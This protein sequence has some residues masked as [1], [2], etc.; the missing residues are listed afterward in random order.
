MKTQQNYPTNSPDPPLEPA[1]EV[2][3][4][5]R[6]VPG[7]PKPGDPPGQPRPG[8]P[9]P[10]KPSPNSPG[11]IRPQTLLTL[12]MAALLGGIAL[13]QESPQN[14]IDDNDILE[15]IEAELRFDE[16]VSAD[17]IDVRVDEGIV[18]LS[19]NAFTLLA[20]QRAVRLVGSLKGVRTVVDR[21]A[22]TSTRRTDQEILDDVKA[23]LRDDPVVEAQQIRVT[24]ANGKVTLEG[25]VDSFAE[26]QL[27]ARAVTGVHGVVDVD[28]Q[29]TS[30]ADTKRPDSEIRPEI[31]RRFELSPY[32]AEGLIEVDVQD[33]IVSL[34]GVV[35]S[36]NERGIASVLARVAGVRKVNT[37]DL[38]VKWWLDRERRR[39]KFTVV[40][41]D[42]QIKKAVEDALLYDPRVRGAKV[43]VRT[44]Q[45]AVSL[46]G[47][48]SSLAAKRAAEQDAKNTL[49]VRRV[50]NNL[51][52][53]VPDWPGDLEV[54]K[55]ATEAL[56]RDAH[57]FASNLKASSHFGKVFVSGTVNSYFE[58]QRAETVVANVRGAMEVVNRVSVDAR[59]QPKEDGEIYEDVER[60]FRFSSIVDAE[61]IRISVVDGVVALRGT[62]DT[63]HEKTLAT[64]HANQGG[65]L[66]VINKLAV[67]S[68]RE[69]PRG[70][71]ATIIPKRTTYKLDSN[72]NTD[73][74]RD[75]LELIEPVR[76]PS[77]LPSPPEVDLVLKLQNTA[78]LPVGVRLGHDKGSLDLSLVGDGAINVS[79]EQPVVA[80]FRP[81]RVVTIKPGDHIKIPIESLQ[82]GFRNAS[83]RWYWTRPGDYMLQATLIWPTDVTGFNMQHVEAAPVKLI[84]ST[85][86]KDKP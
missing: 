70:L 71:K 63:L 82:Y 60:R 53:K 54:T 83:D 80:D 32:L 11:P 77:A 57:L 1:P 58:K 72:W 51:K 27:T 38:E 15:A 62:V 73:E 16:A 28:N 14:P 18:E 85:K 31:L 3:P 86:E 56:G 43:E 8:D 48:V 34:G 4:P 20:M 79:V 46:F 21:I 45:G 35:G 22:V 41:N 23:A 5:S 39:D 42:V 50:I 74:F 7:T 24:V 69:T 61:Q 84:V 6:P 19:G 29:I 65:A 17:T 78:Q 30:N 12:V 26:R 81:G 76:D 55:Q 33:G 40:R 2:S 13:A 49:G 44:R 25:E 67:R 10:T 52:V 9:P 47:N 66:R 37:G 64:Q 75:Y 36:V 59:W 68:R